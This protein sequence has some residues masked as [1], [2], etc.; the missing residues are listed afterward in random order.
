MSSSGVEITLSE[1]MCMCLSYIASVYSN[2]YISSE[3][4]NDENDNIILHFIGWILVYKIIS[5]TKMF[6]DV[7]L[8]TSYGFRVSCFSLPTRLK[9]FV[10]HVFLD[11]FLT[12]QGPS[13]LAKIA[14]CIWLYKNIV[15]H[16]FKKTFLRTICTYTNV[17]LFPSI[18]QCAMDS[19]RG[20]WVPFCHFEIL[21]NFT[22]RFIRK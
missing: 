18:R 1:Y 7:K 2:N 11:I 12:M 20:S 21:N 6:H 17:K 10:S 3:R 19:L 8:G 16:V 5:R 4:Q 13:D 22:D 15:I 9:T 14:G